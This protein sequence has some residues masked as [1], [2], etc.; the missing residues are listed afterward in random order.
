M[1][2]ANDQAAVDGG[3]E[4][5]AMRVPPKRAFLALDGEP[6]RITFARSNGALSHKLRS[7]GPSAPRLPH[8]M[9]IHIYTCIH[10]YLLHSFLACI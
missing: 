4:P 10:Y 9:P 6:V 2:R 8:S 5:R 3:S 1:F 7:I